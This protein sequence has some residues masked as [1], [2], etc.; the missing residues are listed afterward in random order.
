MG[1]SEKD[2]MTDL[3]CVPGIRWL[4]LSGCVEGMNLL[5]GYFNILW[6]YPNRVCYLTVKK[7][8]IVHEVLTVLRICLSSDV[9]TLNK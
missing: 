5:K 7:L 1:C 8:V 4:T 6:I 9:T 3:V 2:K